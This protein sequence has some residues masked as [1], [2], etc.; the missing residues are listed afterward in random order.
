M[1]PD[2]HCQQR[3]VVRLQSVVGIASVDD[4]Q[5]VP[6]LGQP[7]PARA[8]VGSC[9]GNELIQKFIDGAPFGLDHG[10]ELRTWL[11]LFRADAV[12]IEGVVPVLGCIVV[13]L[14]VRAT[15]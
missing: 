14:D 3:L 5:L 11:S 7:S 15:T 2:I 12:P 13:D 4:C 6:S 10:S 8:E 9:V 1:L